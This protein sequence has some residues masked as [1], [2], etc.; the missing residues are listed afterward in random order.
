MVAQSFVVFDSEALTVDTSSSF[1][2]PGSSVINSSDTPIGTIF[3]YNGGFAETITLDDTNIGLDQGI[4]NDDD[5]ANHTIIDGGAL[6]ANG[7]SVESE[8]IISIQ[9]IDTFG[10]QVGPII[11]INVFSKDGLTSDVWGFATSQLLTP[12]AQ[13]QVTAGN[14][15][16][17]SPYSSFVTCYAKGTLIRTNTGEKI[18]E[19]LREGDQILTKDSGLQSI[20]WIGSRSVPATGKFAPVMIKAHA[21]GNHQDLL[22]SQQ[23]RMLLQNWKAE[24]LFGEPEILVPA[25]YLVNGDTIY[26]LN[27]GSIKYFHILFDKHEIIFA[28]GAASESFHPGETGFDALEQDTRDE[29]ISIFPQLSEKTRDYGL[30]SRRTINKYEACCLLN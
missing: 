6:I 29:I 8:S 3:T 22:V 12:G 27:S 17:S 20:R 7:T 19:T 14:I 13:Y 18:I 21:L 24:M 10:N 2:T 1:L 23:H 4:F 5:I 15:A 11:S 30:T 25:K 16:G 26:Q 9:E 28:N